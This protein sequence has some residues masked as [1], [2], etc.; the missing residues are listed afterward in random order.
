MTTNL[1]L[2]QAEKNE[3]A[4]Q[5]E[6]AALTADEGEDLTNPA[7]AWWQPHE[8]SEDEYIAMMEEREAY[9]RGIYV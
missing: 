2:T 4:W 5:R 6:L 9:A 8:L 1:I 7:L 3:I